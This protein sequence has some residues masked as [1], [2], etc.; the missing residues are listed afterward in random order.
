MSRPGTS[1]G[2]SA[3]TRRWTQ[4]SGS[5]AGI[6]SAGAD[7][8]AAD[9]VGQDADHGRV[10]ADHDRHARGV[11]LIGGDRLGP[12]RGQVEVRAVA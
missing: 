12:V 8:L 6:V 7:R 5:L 2:Q 3:V 4:P 1:S 9:H 10:D 11:A